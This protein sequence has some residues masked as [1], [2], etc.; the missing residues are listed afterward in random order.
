MPNGREARRKK[1]S[2]ECLNQGGVGH[3]DPERNGFVSP[4][5][6][7]HDARRAEVEPG[8][9]IAGHKSAD[10]SPKFLLMTQGVQCGLWKV[11]C[12][13]RRELVLLARI[14]FGHLA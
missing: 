10:G 8:C 7:E 12:W 13:P 4:D 5:V 14:L 2:I 11:Q 3:S 1:H 9:W 6:E